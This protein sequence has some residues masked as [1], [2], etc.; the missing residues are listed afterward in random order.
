MSQISLI[1]TTARKNPRFD[2]L[3]SSLVRCSYRELIGQIVIVDFFAQPCDDWTDIDVAKRRNEVLAA[4]KSFTSLTPA[5]IQWQPP[6]PNVWAGKFRITPRN[7]WHKSTAL[8]TG[9]CLAKHDYLV[10]SDDRCIFKQ[11]FLDAVKEAIENKYAV[12]G[13]Y[14]KRIGMEY[15]DGV[16]THEGTITGSDSRVTVAQGRKMMCPGTWM[17]GHAF[18]LPTEWMLAVNGVDELWDS[19]SMED[20]HFGQM[21]ENNSYTIYHDP[22][23]AQIQDRTPEVGGHDMKR[24]SKEKHPNDKDDKTH[25]LIKKLWDRKRS[26]NPFNFSDMRKTVLAGGLFPIPLGPHQDWFDG[27]NLKDMA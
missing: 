23:M 12:C 17:F 1:Y 16:I 24:S 14:E 27:Q 11:T 9:L 7:W 19:V 5:E 13:T 25:S 10:F 22:R 26:S 2:W 8:N 21:L 15:A 6:K 4:S 20:T 18:G 3:F